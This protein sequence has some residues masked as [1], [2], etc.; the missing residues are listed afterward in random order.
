MKTTLLTLAAVAALTVTAFGHSK[1]LRLE[2]RWNAN[3]QA[4]FLY[5]PTETST[6]AVAKQ[7]R[8]ERETRMPYIA[9]GERP[10]RTER[11]WNAKG[12]S[13]LVYV[14]DL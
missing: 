3:G 11:R 13:F 2:R 4:F 12:E 8:Y 7:R 14:P 5:V 10:L 9:E 6:T 1:E